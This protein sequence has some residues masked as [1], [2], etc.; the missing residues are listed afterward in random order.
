[1]TDDR[2]A[3]DTARDPER[4]ALGPVRG[5]IRA[6]AGRAAGKVVKKVARTA[7]QKKT[8]KKT[9]T[10]AGRTVK[11]VAKTAAKKDKPAPREAAAPRTATARVS[12]ARPKAASDKTA[13][14]GKATPT[15]AAAR[16]A[17]A[18]SGVAPEAAAPG[19]AASE[20]MASSPATPAA[21]L[22]GAGPSVEVPRPPAPTH[23]GA[24]ADSGQEQANGLGG[25]LALWGPLIIVGF[26]VLVFRGGDE[27]GSTA[28]VGAGVSARSAAAAGAPTRAALGPQVRGA[29]EPSAGALPPERTPDHPGTGHGVAGAS[30]R[31]VAMRTSMTHGPASA[32]RGSGT[33]M[34]AGLPGSLYS[35]PSGPYRDPRTH[36]LPAGAGADDWI[37]RTAGGRE[38]SGHRDGGGAP[39]QWV[40]CAPPYYWCPAPGSPAW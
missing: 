28:V 40:R 30:D 32:G 17:A 22:P 7:G 11:K 35:P 33:P 27:R 1:M 20:S 8:T 21:S 23:P 2:I 12:A 37:G 24:Y 36:G 31:G 10:A 29:V 9:T 38:D 13:P 34:P 25:L 19:A 5:G 39:A 18:A 16:T 4:E 15:K 6:A 3:K 14:A 26:L